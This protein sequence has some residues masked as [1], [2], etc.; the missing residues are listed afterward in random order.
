M[1]QRRCRAALFDLASPPPLCLHRILTYSKEKRAQ[2]EGD[3]WAKIFQYNIKKGHALDRLE[4]EAAQQR[5]LVLRGQLT[6]Q[7]EE[8]DARKKAERAAEKAYAEAQQVSFVRPAPTLVRPPHWWGSVVNAWSQVL[9][10]SHLEG[11]RA[12]RN[13]R[14]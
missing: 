12:I 7:M 2:V 13:A 9:N 10:G 1:C 3:E 5:K 8:V 4:A 11:T 6:Q 14:H